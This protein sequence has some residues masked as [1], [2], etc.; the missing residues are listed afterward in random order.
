MRDAD[1]LD[2]LVNPFIPERPEHLKD[3]FGW[4]GVNYAIE[5]SHVA[6]QTYEHFFAHEEESRQHNHEASEPPS[7]PPH[8]PVHAP[9]WTP[10]YGPRPTP[11][12]PHGR[13]F[14]RGAGF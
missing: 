11:P 3:L 14:S 6:H 12:L 10:I 5:G 13:G 4:F 9:S 2:S 8:K 7:E 1:Y